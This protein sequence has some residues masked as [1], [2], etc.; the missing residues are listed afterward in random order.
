MNKV[1]HRIFG[2]K[3]YEV[4]EDWRKLHS[5]GLHN[6]YS[7]P[8]TGPIKSWW[9]RWAQYVTCM[10]AKRQDVYKNQNERTNG[11]IHS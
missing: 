3:R 5:E 11:K 6:F 7:S 9:I 2:P 8:N 1:L 4:T 10:G